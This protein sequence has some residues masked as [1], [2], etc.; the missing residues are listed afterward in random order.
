[1]SDLLLQKASKLIVFD[2]FNRANGVIGETDTGESWQTTLDSLAVFSILNNKAYSKNVG[3]INVV[4]SPINFK[5]TAKILNL[6]DASGIIFRVNNSYKNLLRISYVGTEWCLQSRSTDTT[7]TLASL[8][9]ATAGDILSVI[10]IND[11][12]QCYINGLL[13]ASINTSFNHGVNS[14]GIYSG[15]SSVLNFD[16]FSVEAI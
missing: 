8:G 16:N 9:T 10:V 7:T 12:V 3:A 13:K 2:G 5:L 14:C 4:P 11:D 6:T 1:M 15:D